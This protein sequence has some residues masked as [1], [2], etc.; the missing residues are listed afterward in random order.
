VNLPVDV[1]AL[2]DGRVMQVHPVRECIPPCPVHEPSVHPLAGAP[3]NWREDRRLW[4]RICRHG[5]GHPDPDDLGYKRLTMLPQVYRMAAYES[6]GCDGCCE[7]G[8]LAW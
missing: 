3:L 4:E 2:H 7:P 8:I 6:H 1:I 5:T